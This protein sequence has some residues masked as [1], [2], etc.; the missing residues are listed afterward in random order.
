[1]ASMN[2]GK[3]FLAAVLIGAAAVVAAAYFPTE[4]Q[5]VPPPP[6]TSA[7]PAVLTQ[8]IHVRDQL[9]LADVSR[10]GQQ[11]YRTI[12][13]LRP[14]GEAKDQPPSTAVAEAAAKAGLKF[15]YVPTPNGNIP[16]S[17]VADLTRAL[18]GTE[19][20]VLLYCRSGSR[21]ARVWAL[22]EASR[23]GGGDA[24]AIAQA[25]KAA[26]QKVDDLMPRITTRI[27]ARP[28]SR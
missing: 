21:A 22:A 7:G 6:V 3:A 15:A 26:G 9:R 18:T 27:A 10:L 19:G 1:M 12:I 28:G 2:L 23:P 13:D 16:D 17:V 14:D 24:A 5:P 25:V 8:G 20:P 4:P 11:G